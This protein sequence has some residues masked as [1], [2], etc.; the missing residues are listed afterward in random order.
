M[1]LFSKIKGGL[2]T[3]QREREALLNAGAIGAVTVP[4]IQ[5]LELPVGRI[6][7]TFELTK[8][9]RG[10][11]RNDLRWGRPDIS[12]DIQGASGPLAVERP[13]GRTEATIDD[14]RRHRVSWVFFDVPE[15]GTYTVTAAA[16]DGW[17]EEHA[18]NPV[19]LFDP[20]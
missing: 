2:E 6:Q 10:D 14:Q 13:S 16:L 20:A 7:T 19:L 5:Q 3:M 12:L 4:G 18:T 17:Y 8:P 11:E 15:A 1:G 9:G